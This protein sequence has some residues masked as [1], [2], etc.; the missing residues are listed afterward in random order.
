[1]MRLS[2]A[3]SLCATAA[4]MNCPSASLGQIGALSI[5]CKAS[6]FTRDRSAYQFVAT[7]PGRATSPD[8]RLVVVQ[9]AYDDR[10]PP[11]VVQD[12]AGRTLG[13]LSS[14]SDD[15]PFVV[16]WS[17]D[18]HW[19]AV[20][21]HV[22]SFMDELRL[23]EIVGEKIIERPGLVKAAKYQAVRRYPCL[24]SSAVLPKA[25]RWSKDSRRLVLVTI[26]S[27]YACSDNAKKG[28]W[29]PLWM[30]ADVGTGRID[31]ASIRVDKADGPL[32]EPSETRYRLL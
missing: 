2:T 1:M 32:K 12:A 15:M 29:W 31:P 3:L 11:I 25:M 22:G 8:R 17:P 19:I 24:T 9:R 6:G 14:I 7:C 13:R 18:S 27:L 5:D 4:L 26:S 10:Q 30:V 28:D 23:F 20:N 16:L 21:H